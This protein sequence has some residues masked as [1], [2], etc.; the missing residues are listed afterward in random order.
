MRPHHKFGASRMLCLCLLLLAWF[1]AA[2][3]GGL[4]VSPIRVDLSD[5]QP[6]AALTLVN[7][8]PRTAVVQTQLLSW[9]ATGDTERYRP[10]DDIVAA[11][12]IA[13][14]QPGQ[15]QIVRVGLNRDADPGRELAYR[16]YIEEVPPPPTPGQQGLQ[17]A[18]RIGVPIFIKPT[19]PARPRLEWHAIRRGDHSLTLEATNTGDAH[20]RLLSLKLR[21]AGAEQPLIEQQIVG[22]LLPGQ[23]RRWSVPLKARL[24]DA[25]LHLSVVTKPNMSDVDLELENP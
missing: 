22:Y 11:P 16:L 23:S 4:G 17:V 20:L 6:T 21:P 18:L 1:G 9:S 2:S 19:Q 12:P 5:S 10:T 13:T 3:A 14:I 15:T 8:G 25:R 7:N 24:P